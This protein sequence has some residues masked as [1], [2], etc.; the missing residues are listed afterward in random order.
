MET[1]GVCFCQRAHYSSYEIR[2]RGRVFIRSASDDGSCFSCSLGSSFRRTILLRLSSFPRYQPGQPRITVF[3]PFPISI[4]FDLRRL[5]NTTYLILGLTHCEKDSLHL[6]VFI[7]PNGRRGYKCYRGLGLNWMTDKVSE[8]PSYG[9]LGID[10][11]PMYP[12]VHIQS[13]RNEQGMTR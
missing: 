1:T 9:F 2:P 10:V 8:G 11:V 7:L 12:R 3:Q 5:F 13:R 4:A 6:S